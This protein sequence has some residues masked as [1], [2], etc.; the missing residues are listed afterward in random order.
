MNKPLSIALKCKACDNPIN[1]LDLDT[2]LC[3]ICLA[4]VYDLVKDIPSVQVKN[5]F[6]GGIMSAEIEM[7]LT[8]ITS[9]PEMEIDIE[10][11]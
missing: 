11:T 6:L 4:V 1:E 3:H 2:E 10:E 9:I 5:Y 7:L 8:E